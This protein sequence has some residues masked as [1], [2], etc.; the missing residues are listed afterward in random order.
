MGKREGLANHEVVTIVVYL[1][2]GQLSAIDT[3]DIAIKAAEIAPGR[4]SWRKYP[5]QINLD[6]VRKRLWDACREDKGGYLVGSEKDGWRVTEKGVEFASGKLEGLGLQGAQ[7]P[8]TLREKQWRGR[9]RERMLASEAFNVFEEGNV[10]ELT[11]SDAYSF[12]RID[13]H[14]GKEARRARVER[15]LVF[16]GD[17]EDLGSLV[18]KLADLVVEEDSNE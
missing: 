5:D 4:F 18:R 7:M 1:L 16:F 3:E 14:V 12:F 11:K 8:M 10:E 6:A 15:A 13:E 9:E 17:D 2:R